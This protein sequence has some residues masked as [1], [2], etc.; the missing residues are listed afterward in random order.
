MKF[1]NHSNDQFDAI[2]I[3]RLF[4]SDFAQPQNDYDFYRSRSLDQIKCAIS[5][6]SNT[7]SYPDFIAAIAQANAFI[8]SA[9]N[10]ELI[11]LSEKVEW[12]NAVHE[13]HKNQLIEA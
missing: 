6:I 1:K 10:L 9:Y 7:H 12:V 2:V 13:A 3:G 8:D 5:N 11:N 4:A